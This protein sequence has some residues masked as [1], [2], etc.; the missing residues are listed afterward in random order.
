M[1][2]RERELFAVSKYSQDGASDREQEAF[3]ILNIANKALEF[4]NGQNV[5]RVFA[6]SKTN[7][8][9]FCFKDSL[10]RSSVKVSD[11]ANN[12][13]FVVKD[14]LVMGEDVILIN[15]DSLTYFAPSD[16]RLIETICTKEQDSISYDALS[17]W[18]NEARQKVEKLM[19]DS[20]S[21][22]VETDYLF[23]MG[24]L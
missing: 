17:K 21:I 22:S 6:G 20:S 24:D 19:Q 11:S 16:L 4:F 10:D 5:I 23:L 1:E 13:Y 7:Y 8:S 9:A 15:D 2:F 14:L 18:L 12:E 3:L